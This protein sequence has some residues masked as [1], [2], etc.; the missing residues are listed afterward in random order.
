MNI[1]SAEEM[2]E[3]EEVLLKVVPRHNYIF[4]FPQE[5]HFEEI[6]TF[7]SNTFPKATLHG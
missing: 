7:T 3:A 6:S 1:L 2:K 5:Q 4:V